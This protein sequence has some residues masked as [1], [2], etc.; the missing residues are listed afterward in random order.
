MAK[1]SRRPFSLTRCLLQRA[2][3]RHLV[4]RARHRSDETK[5]NFTPFLE[6]PEDQVVKGKM[7]G[8]DERLKDVEYITVAN[9]YQ[10]P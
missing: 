8:W 1:I 10:T 2:T 4:T 9:P 5:D 7:V 6:H 3:A